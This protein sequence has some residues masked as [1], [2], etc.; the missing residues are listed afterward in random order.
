MDD[1]RAKL[2]WPDDEGAARSLVVQTRH[3]GAILGAPFPSN[4]LFRGGRQPDL[5]GHLSALGH[6]GIHNPDRRARIVVADRAR[7]AH[8]RFRR[9][10]GRPGQHDVQRLAPLVGRVLQRGDRDGRAPLAGGNR[11]LPAGHRRVVRARRRR[12]VLGAP[13]QDDVISGRRAQVDGEGHR[14]TLA[15]LRRIADHDRRPVVDCDVHLIA[16]EV[17]IDSP[18][19]TGNRLGL[20]DDDADRFGAFVSRVGNGVHFDERASLASGDRHRARAIP[21][22]ARSGRAWLPRPAPPDSDVL[23][24][25]SDHAV[26]QQLYREDGGVALVNRQRVVPQPHRQAWRGAVQDRAR[27]LHRAALAR[28]RRVHRLGQA[29]DHRLVERL[30][31]AVPGHIDDDRLL[32]LA[33]GER[34]RAGRQRGVARPGLRRAVARVLVPGGDHQIAGIAQRRLE[35]EFLAL[36]RA[37]RREGDRGQVRFV[38]DRRSHA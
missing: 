33:S 8:P 21:V 13:G 27:P 34:D 9:G 2:A 20:R 35:F 38:Q 11:D 6:E 19:R 23:I 1:S 15:H 16:E 12:A 32:R 36:P 17:I 14:L 30:I 3:C 31:D 18:R 37:R 28:E 22:V 25:W 7:G 10:A 24:P 29:E 4:R 5:E 26:D